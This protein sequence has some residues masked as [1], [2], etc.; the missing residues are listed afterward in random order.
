MAKKKKKLTRVQNHFR[1]LKQRRTV[2]K[3]KKKTKKALWQWSSGIT[4]SA[5]SSFIECPEQ[6]S[7]NYIDGYTPKRISVPLE[8]GSLFHLCLEHQFLHKNLTPTQ[9]AFKISEAYM[10]SKTNLINSNERDL[11]K[12]VVAQLRV[13]YPLYCE[14]WAS[15]DQKIEWINRE[16]KFRVP[17][18][19]AAESGPIKLVLRGMRD[20]VIRTHG[21]LGIFETKTKS[22]I[23]T[24]EIRDALKSDM[25]TM[26]Y[27][28]ATY[29][30]IEYILR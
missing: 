7:L 30:V 9:I 2:S 21:E 3:K 1:V 29:D 22:R 11:M 14:H 4:F 6:F 20:G 26:F 25:Q 10:Q 23:N 12:E 19:I 18:T 13:V 17:Y 8:Y 16:E 24:D 27:I 5:L 15:D 28:L